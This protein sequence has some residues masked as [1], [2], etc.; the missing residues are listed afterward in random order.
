MLFRIKFT[1]QLVSFLVLLFIFY[2]ACSNAQEL[3]TLVKNKNY[4]L[5]KSMRAI[6]IKKYGN[7]EVLEITNRPMPTFNNKQ[8]LIKV[9]ATGINPIDYKIRKGMLRY[10]MPVKFPAI[11]GYDIC[12][13][14]VAVREQVSNF[15]KGDMVVV[16]S[17]YLEGRGY[18]EYIAIDEK[19]IVKKPKNLTT[20]EAAGVP[21]SSLTALQALQKY[22][23][24]QP[25][26]K[27]MIIGGT[28][29]VGTFA[30]QLAKVLGAKVTAVCSTSGLNLMK[31]FKIDHIIDY[32]KDALFTD[33]KKY[34]IIFDTVGKCD[35]NKVKKYLT[36]NGRYIS[37][38]PSKSTWI[39]LITNLFTNQKCYFVRVKPN[40][41]DLEYIVNQLEEDNIK[42]I[43][44]KVY[45][46]DQIIEA[47]KYSESGHAHGKII[48]TIE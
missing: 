11:L 38:L 15:K 35:F 46:F 30:T 48:L 40:A 37:T 12:G 20:T 9:S 36:E 1:K 41:N 18:A 14:I 2:N 7:P 47:H 24:I 33:N 39:S 4:S 17:N 29:G 19:Y 13:E 42:L 10:F 34:D 21:L 6:V 27:V 31:S 45:P 16:F 22:G 3:A 5:E 25:N 26:S 43:V 32:K 23:N 44:D 28:G 8:A